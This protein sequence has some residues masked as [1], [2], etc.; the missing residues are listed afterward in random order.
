[1]SAGLQRDWCGYT[2]L[3]SGKR[4][5]N[6]DLARSPPRAR[7]TAQLRELAVQSRTDQSESSKNVKTLLLKEQVE[8]RQR[9]RDV[10]SS[11]DY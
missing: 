6:L 8:D 10:E 4:V 5:A 3:G 9:R 11:V 1:M 7:S 2:Q